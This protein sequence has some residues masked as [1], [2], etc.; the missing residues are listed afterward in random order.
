MFSF[1][2]IEFGLS[3]IAFFC[4]YWLLS[5]KPQLQNLLLLCTSYLIVYLSGQA[6]A[7]IALLIFTVFIYVIA[8][9]IN[10]SS[11]PRIWLITGCIIT[12][13]NLI[14]WKYFDFFRTSLGNSLDMLRLNTGWLAE[15]IL[16]LGLSYYSF[17]AISYL[18]SLYQGRSRQTSTDRH[19]S[20]LGLALHLAFFPTIT[21]GPIA[22]ACDT[23]G[24]TDISG[25]SCG[26]VA[27]I[28]TSERRRI[29]APTLALCLIVMALMKNWWLS[30]WIADN[31]VDPVFANPMQYQS[32]EILAAIY[33]YTVQLFFNFSG[34][35]DLMVAIGLLLGFRLPVNFRAPLLAHN[36]REFWLRWHISLSTWIRDYIYIPLGGSRHG[37]AR[38]QLNLL[39][40]MVLSGIWH[41]NGWHFLIWGLL[42]GAGMILLN[43]GDLLHSRLRHCTLEQARNG[44]SNSGKAGKIISIVLTVHFVCFCFVFFRA[45]TLNDAL[46]LLHALLYNHINVPLSTNPFYFFSLLLLAWVLYPLLAK[47]ITLLYERADTLPRYSLILP[48]LL[49]LVLV[50]IC[51]PAG[52]PGF[53]YAN[54]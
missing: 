22:R 51:A 11:K 44:L 40:S 3:F 7:L 49:L 47:F 23:R 9:R 15:V 12:L 8:I 33:G 25:K 41:G 38:T 21:A 39:I 19:F 50:L 52:I 27:Q 26:M 14:L 34:Y 29:L 18:V 16:P 54:F 17:Q 36:I 30:G 46:L 20:L 35:S 1:I 6:Q 24:L 31:W 4:L 10:H 45:P 5:A 28:H 2:S 13:L 42:H 43:I 48:L 32:L 53:I 37:T